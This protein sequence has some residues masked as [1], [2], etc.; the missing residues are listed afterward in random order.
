MGNSWRAFLQVVVVAAACYS[1]QDLKNEGCRVLCIR[2]GHTSGKSVKNVCVCED[3]KG[4]YEDYAAGRVR[5]GHTQLHLE[6]P[7]PK[8]RFYYSPSSG[9]DEN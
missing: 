5:L 6:D 7:K 4:D 3:N 2:D 1:L 9:E 8:P